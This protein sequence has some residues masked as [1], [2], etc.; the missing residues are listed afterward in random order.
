MKAPLLAGAS[1]TF[2]LIAFAACS[3]TPADNPP[4]LDASADTATT[5]AAIDAAEAGPTADEIASFQ[6]LLADAQTQLDTSGTPGASIAV[7]LHGKLAF[8]AGLGKKNVASGAMVTTST[9]FRA[10]SMSKMIVAATAM[11]LV[12]D[13]KLD[14]NAPITT[15]LP[16]FALKAPFD[17]ST[18][19]LEH[20]LTHTSGFP[21]DTISQCAAAT[22]GPRQA[23][24]AANP[25]PLWAPPGAVYDYSNT[26]F[27]LASVVLTAA[28][29]LADTDYEKLAH[30]RVFVPAGMTTAT[31]DA[32]AAMTADYATGYALDPANKV[33]A[34]DEPSALD[35]PLLHP[36]GG[37]MAT[38]SDYA[39]FAEALLAG[40][41][42]ML[43]KD[44]VDAME[45]PHADTRGFATQS[46]GYGLVH[47]FAPYPAH[48]SVWHDGSL[49]GFLSMLWMIPD[50]NL[51]VVVLVNARGRKNVA[52]AIIGSALGRFIP[53]ARPGVATK[54]PSASWSKYAGTYD[55]AFGTLGVG[56][57]VSVGAAD[58]GATAVTIDAPN[59]TDFAGGAFPVHG[60]MQ[61]Q[62]IDQWSLPDGTSATFF[63]NDAG[64]TTY[65]ATRRGVAIKP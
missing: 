36:P 41:G 62:A 6:A 24:F 57:N 58:G 60:V 56:V 33:V 7:V 37:V 13:G 47:Q 22:S 23:F 28:A 54:T 46:Y 49:P 48:A 44:G 38:A 59:A 21:S 16:W 61:Q 43:S 34:T 8:A 5:D 12:R 39:H 31:F 25:Q 26:G 1:T 14:V 55:D 10:A 9:L 65:L 52:E 17:A 15:Y 2:A 30:D 20:L 64:T 42:A 51:A 32:A 3:S 35:C 53:D 50:S 45:A 63:P 40:G 18:V 11:S 27:A 19:T 4:V 29:G